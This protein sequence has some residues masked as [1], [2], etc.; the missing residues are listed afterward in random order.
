MTIG[1]RQ[2]NWFLFSFYHL[3]FEFRKRRSFSYLCVWNT[4]CIVRYTRSKSLIIHVIVFVI[5]ATKQFSKDE[6]VGKTI[7]SYENDE[8]VQSRCERVCSYTQN[9]KIKE[10]VNILD[11]RCSY[12]AE[13][14]KKQFEKS[15]KSKN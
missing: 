9:E 6:K 8:I 10:S 11:L 5:A 13:E 14:R 7:H 12:S 4:H 3:W 1:K 15:K 2:C